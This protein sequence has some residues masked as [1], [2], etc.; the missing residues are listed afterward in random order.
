VAGVP[1][2][3]RASPDAPAADAAATHA[4]YEQYA[5]RIQRYCLRRL[6]SREEAEDAAQSTFLNAFRGLRRGVVPHAEAAWLYKIA[7]NVCL[8]RR[9]SSRRR[10]RVETTADVEAVAGV[11]AAPAQRADEL[12]GLQS[13]LEQLPELQRRALLLREWQGLSYRELA[14][15]LE[16]SEAAVETLLFRARKAL[17]AGLENP[18][19]TKGRLRGPS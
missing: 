14:A 2:T 12:I 9:R 1:S 16:L 5:A 10:G 3:R 8:A 13:V 17:A 15:E 4:L 7:E 11:T 19:K 6:G 18:S